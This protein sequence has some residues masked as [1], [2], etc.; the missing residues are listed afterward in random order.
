MNHTWFFTSKVFLASINSMV[1]E[2]I[3]FFVVSADTLK[4]IKNTHHSSPNTLM[5]VFLNTV[6]PRYHHTLFFR[7]SL[8]FLSSA[9][10]LSS[11]VT[12]A[13]SPVL[14]LIAANSLASTFFSSSSRASTRRS[15]SPRC[16]TRDRIWEESK[17]KRSFWYRHQQDEQQLEHLLVHQFH[18]NN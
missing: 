4:K 8:T 12:L 2:L 18:S 9:R 11:V 3:L 14:S 10:C 1:R 5:T 16:C 17:L 15:C 6:K 13:V 7:N